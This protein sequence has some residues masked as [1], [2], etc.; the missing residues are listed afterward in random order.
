MTYLYVIGSPLGPVKIG[1]S[2]NPRSRLAQIRTASPVPVDIHACFDVGNYPQ[3]IE[4]MVHFALRESRQAGEWFDIAAEQAVEVI[5]E[6]GTTARLDMRQTD[7]TKPTSGQRLIKAAKQ[8]REIAKD[9]P[10][11]AGRAKK[12]ISLRLD[13]DVIDAFRA[14]GKG[15]QSRINDALAA[16]VSSR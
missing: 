4:R 3:E 16:F 13:Q 15:W 9:G 11:P 7:Y 12:L 1:F 14:T 6:M 10:A 8:A 5:K 2:S